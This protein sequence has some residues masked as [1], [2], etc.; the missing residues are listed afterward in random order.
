MPQDVQIKKETFTLLPEKAVLWPSQSALLLADLH[1]GKA[2]H[3]RKEGIGIPEAI[4]EEDYTRL[5]SLFEKHPTQHIY[6][7]GD[8][9]HSVHN[10][11]WGRVREMVQDFKQTQFH[12]VLGNHDIL[13]KEDYSYAGLNVVGEE[14]TIGDFTLAHEPPESVHGTFTFCGH[15][16]PGVMIKGRGRQYLRLPCFFVT[17][18][19]MILPAFGTFTGLKTLNITGSDKAY[20]IVKDRVVGIKKELTI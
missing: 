16:H 6:F 18:N 4:G 13:K 19:F 5:Y 3:F 1:L 12:L 15:I 20:A 2:Q 14:L 9:F 8:L 7:L 17:E 10:R 11:E